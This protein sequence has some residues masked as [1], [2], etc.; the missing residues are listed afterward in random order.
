MVVCFVVIGGTVDHHC[1]SFIVMIVT[2]FSF[3][4]LILDHILRLL[5]VL[6]VCLL[7]CIT[8][9]VWQINAKEN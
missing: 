3:H 7:S 6:T 1:L 4:Y 2:I 9:E 5:I 8:L